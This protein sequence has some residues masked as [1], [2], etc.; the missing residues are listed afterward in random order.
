MRRLFQIAALGIALLLVDT[1]LMGLFWKSSGPEW[2]LVL[3]I[4]LSAGIGLTLERLRLLS[5]S[6]G[7]QSDHVEGHGVSKTLGRTG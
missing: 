1:L 5:G 4:L 7:R 3:L 6:F 2:H